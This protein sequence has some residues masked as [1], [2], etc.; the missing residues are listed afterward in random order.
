MTKPTRDEHAYC[1]DMIQ[2]L[3]GK[4]QL[5]IDMLETEDGAFTFPD[6]DTWYQT[7]REP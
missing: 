2:E 5:V 3:C 6:G 4:L 1:Q 7:G